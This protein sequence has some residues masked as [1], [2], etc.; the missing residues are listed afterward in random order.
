MGLQQAALL[1]T[2]LAMAPFAACNGAAT[3][4]PVEW[5]TW[6]ATEHADPEIR[7]IERAMH[8]RLNKDRAAHGLTPLAYDEG[9][10][11][12]A[13][14]HSADMR[15][16]D[17][18]EHES[19]LTGL[20]ED[21]MIRAGYLAT[22][23]RENLAL[24]GDV[25]KAED[26]LLESPGH[27]ANILS[28]TITHVG[29]G[30][31]RGDSSG[32]PRAL[33]ITQVFA[34]PVKLDTPEDASKKVVAILDDG[35][36]KAGLPPMAKHA[37]LADLAE[38]YVSELPDEVPEGAVESI[39]GE[40]S[41]HLNDRADHGLSAIGIVAQSFFHAAEFP[42]PAGLRDAMIR[43]YGIATRAAKDARGRPRVKVLLLLGRAAR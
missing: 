6:T 16:H 17:F 14:A 28:T 10:A 26:N 37:M 19:P 12:V 35:R 39:G 27:K 1:L 21:R 15:D 43:H 2:L 29:I 7:S 18:F 24:A 30:I 22:E 32:D 34:Q 9:L 42:L 41:S 4:P 23:M 33:T 25:D 3:R 11:D 36:K 5:A 20:L 40:V 13:R 31:V 38:R 8:A